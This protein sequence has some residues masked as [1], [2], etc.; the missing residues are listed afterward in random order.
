MAAET[1][2]C[3]LFQVTQQKELGRVGSTQQ[4]LQLREG[5]DLLQTRN[6]EKEGLMGGRPCHPQSWGEGHSSS[7][8][9]RSTWRKQSLGLEQ[10]SSVR[11]SCASRML[12]NIIL[13]RLLMKEC[14]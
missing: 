2:V 9:E 8:L 14:L 4:G 6:S 5:L 12:V 10:F 13:P 3:F 1:S 11:E 7:L